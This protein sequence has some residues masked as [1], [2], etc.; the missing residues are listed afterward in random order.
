MNIL[1]QRQHYKPKKM[2]KT[3]LS[4]AGSDPGGG[5]GIQADL[6]TMTAI[7]VYGAAAITC[8]TVQNSLGVERVEPLEPDL[9][10]DQIEAVM[11]DH[12][13]THIK[14]GMVGTA[15]VAEAIRDA[16]VHFRGE[17]VV[18]P[19]LSSTTGQ[20]LTD[21][22]AL[23]GLIGMATV[24]TPNIPEL[25]TAAAAVIGSEQDIITAT[26]SL[27]DGHR[28]LRCILVKG[29]HAG[30]GGQITDYLF[31]KTS[32]RMEKET[33]THPFIVTANTHGTGCTLA[34]AFTAWHSL[35]GNYN[36]A[37]RRSI[38][39]LQKVLDKSRAAQIVRNPD[40]RGG[41]LHHLASSP[42]H[43]NETLRRTA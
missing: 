17:L 24:L 4:I 14:I 7:G 42:V 10:R 26:G 12:R 2:I 16:L 15:A 20:R 36:D 34:A 40:G 37:F 25:E 35:T 38:A 1:I 32:G 19:V 29:G 28:H 31:R 22:D 9:V 18:D 30:Q 6:K 3:V 41:L 27:L 13:V 11:A 23:A 33:V 5:A 21:R 39:F 8:I 43:H